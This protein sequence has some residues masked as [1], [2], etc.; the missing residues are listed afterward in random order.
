[1]CFEISNSLI[2]SFLVAFDTF[3]LYIT[4]MQMDVH[5]SGRR[6][7]AD[8]V[9]LHTSLLAALTTDRGSC[10][11]HDTSVSNLASGIPL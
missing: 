8:Q 5:P 11:V 7:H 10:Y 6:P 4:E 1:M 9:H 3:E 2:A